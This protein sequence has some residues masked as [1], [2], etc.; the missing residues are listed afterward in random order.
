[1]EENCPKINL[2]RGFTLVE[3]LVVM[4]IIG[5]LATVA[6]ASFRSSQM[7]SR[8]TQ[9]KSD[10]K[11]IS[12][13]LELFY[14][15]YEQYPSASGGLISAC[16]YDP[17]GVNTQG[18]S[19]GGDEMTDGETTYFREMPADPDDGRTYYYRSLEGNQ[20]YQIYASLENPDDQSCI[21]DNCESPTGL[22]S[23]VDCGQQCN[24]AITSP[25][26][27]AKDI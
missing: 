3:L 14:N 20:A 25:N 6:L 12:E 24:F 5:I 10:L 15:D 16:P 9:R 19:W 22:P 11:N 7:R 23:G 18:C 13:A 21:D 8:D 4:A 27:T 26:V 2:K 17:L 1:M